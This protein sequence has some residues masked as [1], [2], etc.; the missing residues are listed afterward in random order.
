MRISPLVILLI[1]ISAC[2]SPPEKVYQI[3]EYSQAS[4]DY[5]K[6]ADR[7][8]QQEAYAEALNLY[9][10]AE[11]YALKRNDQLTIGISK[12]K[13]AQ[14]NITLDN[15]AEAESLIK[16]VEKAN[17]IE[18][19]NLKPSV[20]FI[21]AK[22]LISKGQ[23]SQALELISQ[24]EDYYQADV[25]RRAYYQLLRWSYDYQQFDIESIRQNVETLK[26]RFTARTLNNIEILSFAHLEYARWA[27]DYADLEKGQVIIENAIE[28]FS[29]LE[30]TPKIARTL[31][32]A[33]NFYSRYNMLDRA[34]YYQD[35]YQQL[36]AQN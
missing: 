36:L 4:I 1:L 20:T 19:L 21:K 24:L 3:D 29:L 6:S 5:M 31:E 7:K 16:S 8:R 11:N 17:Q 34:V 15:L 30:L 26:T 27:V 28:H 10:T 25:E 35:L 14:I 2:S 33:A 23:K 13:R 22:L 32:F 9:L 12:L 18:E